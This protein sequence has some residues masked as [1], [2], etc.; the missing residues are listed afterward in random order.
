M[1]G[2]GKV[3]KA[4]IDEIRSRIDIVEVVGAHVQLK[5][6]GSGYKGLCPFHDEK[7]P[8]FHVSP[9]KRFYHCFGC[10]EGGDIFSF[11]MKKAGDNFRNVL[12]EFASRAGVDLTPYQR[13]SS[14]MPDLDRG[15]F[16]AVNKEASDFYRHQ[17]KRSDRARVY[18]EQRGLDPVAQ[19][20]FLLGYAPEGWSSLLDHFT[21]RGI[22]LEVAATIGLIKRRKEGNGFYDALRDRLIFPIRDEHSRIVGFGGRRIGEGDPKNPKY[23]NSPES[24]FYTKGQHLYN[25]DRAIRKIQADAEAPA[26]LC[27]GYMDAV[28]FFRAGI[29]T[30]VAN[31]GTALTHSQANRMARLKKRWILAYDA[32]QAGMRA[33]V[34]A[35][36]MLDPLGIECRVLDLSGKDPD[37]VLEKEGDVALRRAVG[38]ARA[39]EEFLFEA[40]TKT[41]DLSETQ[42]RS[43]A[44]RELRGIFKNLESP[45]LKQ[46]LIRQI[47]D[48]LSLSEDLVQQALRPSRSGREATQQIM[49]RNT[50][51][52][53]LAHQAERTILRE[54]LQEVSLYV[55]GPAGVMSAGLAHDPFVKRALLLLDKIEIT[56]GPIF[57]ELL[58]L[59]EDE[60]MQ[61]FLRSLEFVESPSGD[62]DATRRVEECLAT[63]EKESAR[64]RQRRT[65]AALAECQDPQQRRALTVEYMQISKRLNELESHRAS[66]VA[67]GSI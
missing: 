56:D 7:S 11:L 42:G 45:I 43:E 35:V 47:S 46:A 55:G 23:I 36:Q 38:K 10:G 21:S 30:A 16:Y 66:S 18:L 53:P 6:A 37:E 14:D 34:R 63:I 40:I 52:I 22:N 44:F 5:K 50:G 20:A 17:L 26:L 31:L 62:E 27:E 41:H 3:P 15:E 4:I 65:K 28:A 19:E 9:A 49:Q 2:T 39:I 13:Q 51:E 54:I 29:E 57:N 59:A 64:R 48:G 12:E 24:P 1:A 58:E 60:E 61:R 33:A 8:S 32:D 67:Q 25:M